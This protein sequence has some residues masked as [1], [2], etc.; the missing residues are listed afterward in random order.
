M[1]SIGPTWVLASIGAVVEMGV[2]R[3]LKQL[4][5]ESTLLS[6]ESDSLQF[7]VN[8]VNINKCKKI[9]SQGNLGYNAIR[10]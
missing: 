7:H 2:L 8:F 4:L 3:T 6:T 5:M 10:P 9:A 1:P